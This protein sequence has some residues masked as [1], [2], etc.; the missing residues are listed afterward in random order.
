MSQVTRILSSLDRGEPKAA[1]E[2]LPLVYEELRRLA[3][4]KLTKEPPGQTLQATA[5][6]HE[7]Y[8]KL[9]LEDRHDWKNRTHFYS[10]AAEAMRRILVD[11]ARRRQ[12]RKHGGQLERVNLD[13]LDP[14]IEADNA[15]VLQVHEALDHLAAEDAQKA[16]V[17]KLR[18]FVGLTN[19]ETA[20]LLSI[21]E[22][23][24]RRHWSFAKARLYQLVKDAE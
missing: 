7:A 4:H 12:S 13:A 20:K 24:V 23:S 3:A 21:S 5:L 11:R 8:L 10:V 1:E 14:Q 17:V 16:E 15:L 22:S 9:V 2:L 19:R 6:V 18:F